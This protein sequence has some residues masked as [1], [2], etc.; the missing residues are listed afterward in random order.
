MSCVCPC[1]T[2]D[3]AEPVPSVSAHSVFAHS[4]FAH[5]ESLSGIELFVRH[6][7]SMTTRQYLSRHSPPTTQRSPSLSVRFISVSPSPT[8]SLMGSPSTIISNHHLVHSALSTVV[9][10][11]SRRNHSPVVLSSIHTINPYS[12]T[13]L[14]AFNNLGI[15]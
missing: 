6:A 8:R 14:R 3:V 7:K 9:S 10:D 2:D 12:A 13:Q 4:V 5:S 1:D 15:E 11:A